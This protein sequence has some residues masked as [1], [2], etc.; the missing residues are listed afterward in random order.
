MMPLQTPRIP[1]ATLRTLMTSRVAWIRNWIITIPSNKSNIVT[2]NMWTMF[3]IVETT[4]SAK[5]LLRV[6]FMTLI[7]ILYYTAVM[8][9]KDYPVDILDSLGQVVS[10]KPRMDIDKRKDIYHS[11]H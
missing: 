10:Q 5:V 8:E 2:G 6:K 3:W 7:V 11:V 4:W 1:G 9:H